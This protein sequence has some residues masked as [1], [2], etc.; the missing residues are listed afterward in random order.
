MRMLCTLLPR[1]DSYVSKIMVDIPSAPGALSDH[2]P[3]SE[4]RQLVLVHA[5]SS[6]KP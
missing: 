1:V 2:A 3:C 4:A 5:V 6:E